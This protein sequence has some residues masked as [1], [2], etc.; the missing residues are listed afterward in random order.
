MPNQVLSGVVS[1]VSSAAS[2]QQGVVT[3]DVE[4]RVNVPDDVRLQEGLSAVAN[5][6]L[7]SEDGLLVPNQAISGT[8]DDPRVIVVNG[9]GFDSRSV[10][11]G[12]SDG[13]WTVVQQGL[14]QGDEVVMEVQAV[15]AQQLGFGGFRRGG[16][17]NTGGGGR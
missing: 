6:S 2:S 15:E 8:F 17:G 5:V 1:T 11:L 12:S 4:I 16:G 3:F 14:A 13:F 7:D 9:S 10:V